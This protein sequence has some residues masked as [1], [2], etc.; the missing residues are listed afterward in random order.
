MGLVQLLLPISQAMYQWPVHLL[1]HQPVQCP[2]QQRLPC[3]AAP[4]G[5]SPPLR[6]TAPTPWRIPEAPLPLLPLP[7]LAPR[8]SPAQRALAALQPC[9]PA[10]PDTR[11]HTGPRPRAHLCLLLQPVPRAGVLPYR[12]GF[13]LGTAPEQSVFACALRAVASACALENFSLC[14][15]HPTHP[16]LV[17]A[18]GFVLIP[19][20]ANQ[21]SLTRLCAFEVWCNYFEGSNMVFISSSS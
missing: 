20:L 15:A 2:P 19:C 3:L 9:R 7:A 21:V 17:S 14:W 1:P 18:F 5:R 10:Q 13:L 6:G 4:G 8:A 16:E 11:A 12:A